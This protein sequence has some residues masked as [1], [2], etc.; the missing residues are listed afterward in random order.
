MVGLLVTGHGHFA[1][2]LGSALQLI[3]GTADNLAFVDFEAD[4][5]TETLT[6]NLSN[7]L[8]G[9]KGCDG[10]LVLADL[11]GGSPFKAAVE[12][13]FA[14]PDQ[15]IEVVAGTNLSML[16]EG[17]VMMGAFESPLDMS[18]A[19]IP[20]GKNYIVRFELEEHKDN[21]DEDGI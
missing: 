9:L 18:E 16:V 4:H 8:D 10:V 13:K 20:A 11:A 2:G 12:C 14:R 1:T 15:K 21:E 17:F 19:L 3:A 5:S 7:A 6:N